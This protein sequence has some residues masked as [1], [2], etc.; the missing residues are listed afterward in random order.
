MTVTRYLLWFLSLIPGFLLTACLRR[1]TDQIHNRPVKFVLFVLKACLAIWLAYLVIAT[2]SP[3]LWKYNYLLSGLYIALFADCLCDLVLAV[4]SFTRYKEIKKLGMILLCVLTA[5]LFLQGTI[6]SQTILPHHLRYSSEKL[7]SKHEFVFLSDLHY[8]SPQTQEAVVK[9]LTEIELL[10]PEFV[11]LGGDITDEHTE[12]EEMEW[13][14]EQLG[15]LH[16]PV[17]YVYGNHDRQDRGNYVGGKKFTEE[18]LKSAIEDNGLII[19][20]D[21]FVQIS[22]DLVILGREDDSRLSRKPVEDLPAFSEN[23]YLLCVDHS[24]YQNEDILKTGADLQLSGHTHAGQYFPLKFVYAL[25][26]LNVLGNYRIGDTDVYVSPGIGGWYMPF[27][28]ESHCYYEIIEL[29]PQ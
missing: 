12:K 5:A 29:S 15:S 24:P 25:A 16:T 7:T 19:L 27:R 18:E 11:L 22:D 2:A 26:G 3:F 10:H 4:L 9:A 28:N 13:I 17:Y 14:F 23:T 6:N 20:Q 21:E 1:F 8:G